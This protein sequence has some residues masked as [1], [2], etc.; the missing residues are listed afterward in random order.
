[1]GDFFMI[2]KSCSMRERGE[3]EK[4]KEEYNNLYGF[5]IG[6]NE[7]IVDLG[8]CDLETNIVKDEIKLKKG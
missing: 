1:M 2:G 4:I 8:R 3:Y 5:D 7:H 6:I